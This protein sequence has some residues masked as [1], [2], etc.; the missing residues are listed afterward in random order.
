MMIIEGRTCNRKYSSY[1]TLIPISG[2]PKLRISSCH[3]TIPR[4]EVK[5]G[6]ISYIGPIVGAGI[7]ATPTP[8]K[9]FC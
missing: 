1:L 7:R 8:H 3:V 6:E 5:Y 9:K 2:M 4:K